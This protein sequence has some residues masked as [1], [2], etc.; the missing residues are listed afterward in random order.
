LRFSADVENFGFD[1][2]KHE[3]DLQ[4]SYNK[5]EHVAKTC[6]DSMQI[7]TCSRNLKVLLYKRSSW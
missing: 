2:S 6:W 3:L 7:M 5:L 4:I 1:K